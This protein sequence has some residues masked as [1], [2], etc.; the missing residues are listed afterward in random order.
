MWGVRKAPLSHLQGAPSIILRPTASAFWKRICATA[1][2]NPKKDLLF[3]ETV[4]CDI[5]ESFYTTH[6]PNDIPDEWSMSE[7][8]KSHGIDPIAY[9][10][11]NQWILAFML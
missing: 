2:L 9:G 8:E 10:I 1:P 7:R 4:P 11:E 6:F 5:V 3:D